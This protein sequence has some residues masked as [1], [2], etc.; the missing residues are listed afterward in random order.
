MGDV[1]LKQDPE[2]SRSEVAID[3]LAAITAQ[4]LDLLSLLLTG[5]RNGSVRRPVLFLVAALGLAAA[6]PATVLAVVGL[7]AVMLL[8]LTDTRVVVE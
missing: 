6:V 2:P 4:V 8:A 7:M 5:E 1:P 3:W